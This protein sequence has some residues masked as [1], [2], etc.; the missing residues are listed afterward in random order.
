MLSVESAEYTQQNRMF[1]QCRF[2]HR[3]DD[4]CGIVDS[5]PF[6]YTT[7]KND[8]DYLHEEYFIGIPM[9]DTLQST[10]LQWYSGQD[11]SSCGRKTFLTIDGFCQ[12]AF[13]L[14]AF[15]AIL[16]APKFGCQG[17]VPC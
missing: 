8:C 17:V 12:N 2:D 9:K 15:F 10:A 6:S 5:Q 16:I 11:S 13:F 1:F 3:S 14:T 4:R 7:I